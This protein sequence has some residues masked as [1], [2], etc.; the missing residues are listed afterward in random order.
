MS[1][2]VAVVKFKA[3][4]EGEAVHVLTGIMADDAD[5]AEQ[6]AVWRLYR[7]GD[8]SGQGQT[9]TVFLKSWSDSGSGQTI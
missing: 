9:V 8:V 5:T 2:W 1:E 3:Y 4:Y 6:I 7:A